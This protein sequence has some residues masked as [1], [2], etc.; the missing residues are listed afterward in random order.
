VP[1]FLVKKIN[2][3]FFS[4]LSLVSQVFFPKYHIFFQKKR[5]FLFADQVKAWWQIHAIIAHNCNFFGDPRKNS[6]LTEKNSSKLPLF[7][8]LYDYYDLFMII[9]VTKYF[10]K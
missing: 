8:I 3:G 4:K 6:F 10:L 2:L 9:N 7:Y 1:P 5:S